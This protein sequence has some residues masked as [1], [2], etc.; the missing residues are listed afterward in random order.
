MCSYHFLPGTG[1]P[2]FLVCSDIDRLVITMCV[3]DCLVN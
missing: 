1:I 2:I 3:V